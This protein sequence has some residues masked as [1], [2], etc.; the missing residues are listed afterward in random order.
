MIVRWLPL[1]FAF[2]LLAGPS[3]TGLHAHRPAAE[4]PDHPAHHAVASGFDAAHA[5]AHAAGAMD[6]DSPDWGPQSGAT[7][8]TG[9]EAAL[10]AAPFAL[11]G[12]VHDDVV[13]DPQA[14]RLTGPPSRFRPPSR[15]PPATLPL[16]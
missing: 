8:P 15:A 13:P 6:L 4:A 5:A 10:P 1:L 16:A 11:D 3:G 14:P 2:W 9:G 7:Q 12:A